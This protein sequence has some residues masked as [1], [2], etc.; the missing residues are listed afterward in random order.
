MARTVKLS[1]RFQPD[2]TPLV[3]DPDIVFEFEG[4]D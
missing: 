1:T 4:V 2:V 3:A